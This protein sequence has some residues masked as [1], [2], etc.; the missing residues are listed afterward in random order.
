MAATAWHLRQDGKAF[1]VK[2]HLYPMKDED[3]SSEA[4]IASFLIKTGSKDLGLAEY[5]IDAWVALMIEET[6]DFDADEEGIIDAIHQALAEN[7]DIDNFE[8]RLTD[9]DIVNI[10]KQAHNYNDVDSLY[11]FVDTVRDKLSH[12]QSSIAE[13]LNQQFCRVRF[14]GKYDSE[15]GNNGIWF[16]ISSTN[17]NWNNT[18]YA[19]VAEMKRKLK[20]DTVT[21]CRDLESDMGYNKGGAEYFYQAKDRSPYRN[22]PVDEFLSEE[23]G[24]SPV[25]SATSLNEGVLA[26]IRK[27]LSNGNTLYN[28]AANLETAGISIYRIYSHTQLWRYMLES[29]IQSCCLLDVSLEEKFS[30]AVNAIIRKHNAIDSLKIEYNY[31]Q[32]EIVYTTESNELEILDH[33]EVHLPLAP[34]GITID[35]VS[36]SFIVTLFENELSSIL[37]GK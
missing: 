37:Y 15:Q 9:A 13:S 28:I 10:H 3:L 30:N 7:A 26:T 33:L 18:I 27:D 1:P 20:I 34:H 25:F 24:S 32:D 2:V 29:D 4:E 23:H 35:T 21:I 31:A 6:V 22:M 19:F 12:L 36:E 8:Y 16:R 14:G 5:L 17:Y 11:E